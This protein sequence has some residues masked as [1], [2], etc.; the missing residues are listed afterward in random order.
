MKVLIVVLL[1]VIGTVIRIA[2]GLVIPDESWFWTLL[3]T[4][5]MIVL[6]IVNRQ[7][8]F[9]EYLRGM[10]PRDFLICFFLAGFAL[11]PPGNVL[12]KGVR[13]LGSF[14]VY[15]ALIDVLF[16]FSQRFRKR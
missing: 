6:M 5:S 14:I 10:N 8:T 13:F 4:A 3:V 11:L 12:A 16:C 9:K 7:K 2:T 1:A 15:V